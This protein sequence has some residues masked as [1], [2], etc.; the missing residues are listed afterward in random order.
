METREEENKVHKGVNEDVSYG[1][2][3]VAAG[4]CS[5]QTKCGSYCSIM[6]QH[7]LSIRIRTYHSILINVGF[8]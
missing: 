5:T 4:K 3:V 6:H 7:I 2:R 8:G 1:V